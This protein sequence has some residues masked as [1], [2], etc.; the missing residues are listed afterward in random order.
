MKPTALAAARPTPPARWG[1]RA[2]ES[3]FIM[4]LLAMIFLVAVASSWGQVHAARQA[5]FDR[6]GEVARRIA[7]EVQSPKGTLPYQELENMGRFFQRGVC[8][9]DAEGNVLASS[10]ASLR[11][12]RFL[13][14]EIGQALREQR[15]IAAT[16]TS[17]VGAGT[18]R[19]I[20]VPLAASVSAALHPNDP[21]AL[22]YDYTEMYEAVVG[23]A[24]RAA[25]ITSCVAFILLLLGWLPLSRFSR[26]LVGTLR[27]MAEEL[28]HSRV[29]LDTRNNE[30]AAANQRLERGLQ[31]QQRASQHIEYL[32]F[33]DNL[34][35]LANRAGFGVALNQALE[36][37][38]VEGKP[39]YLFFVDLDRFKQ[40]N[41]TLGHEVGDLL[42]QET[43][44]RLRDIPQSLASVARLGGDE[45]VVLLEN[46]V[47]DVQAQA[48]A[49]KILLSIARPM[50]T[51][52][53][54]LRVTA[55]VGISRYP[56]DGDDDHTLM[57]HADIALYQAKEG[58]RNHFSLFASE[59]NRNSL[60]RLALESNL[61]RAV[62]R[63][64]LVI[65]YQPKLDFKTGKTCGMEAL[66]RWQHPDLGIVSPADFIPIA[67]ETGLIVPIGLW[68]L[69]TA[70]Q[71]TKKWQALG[72]DGLVV[73]VNL[74]PRQIADAGLL[75]NVIDALAQAGLEAK[76]L[77]LE[78]TES[79]IMQDVALGRKV[80]DEL[81]SIGVR[82]AVDDFGTGYSSLATLQ[83][84]PI[85]TLK[86]DRSFVRDLM[87]DSGAVSTRSR[88]T[89]AII[90]MGKA[91]SLHL[92]AEGVET[93]AQSEF[94]SDHG[95]DE[96]Q[97]YYFS[98]PLSTDKFEEF[99]R[100]HR[101]TTSNAES[102]AL[103]V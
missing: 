87:A 57:K 7:A 60:E 91:M 12:T 35:G 54:E 25:T 29:Q 38:R 83:Q 56:R 84:F 48:L 46:A 85:D 75:Q 43:A 50:E 18:R 30:L 74:S 79:A 11:G 95:C 64:E 81:K 42:L 41:D 66:V 90:A 67:E 15:S 78:I 21:A 27:S 28:A 101:Q 89:E 52:G 8:V 96:L 47:D 62:D 70:C 58:G 16:W 65:H 20:I 103:A 68:V 102:E 82:I 77:E 1:A 51:L 61:R 9:I 32:A 97:G 26:R 73:A 100:D 36:R 55:S 14:P 59:R 39:L 76:Y 37:A 33:H 2:H 22:V 63:N 53:Q 10:L 98:K 92:V 17:R 6:A 44:R 34:T 19:Q 86:I 23:Q 24:T 69:R 94:L 49:A 45:F 71:Q 5:T 80:M 13:E 72:L 40:I 93:R 99:L 31:I 88:L 3:R 4:A